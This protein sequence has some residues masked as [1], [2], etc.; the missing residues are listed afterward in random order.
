MDENLIR[1]T[2]GGEAGFWA[3]YSTLQANGVTLAQVRA[4]VAERIALRLIDR[5]R[6]HGSGYI[7]AM[8]QGSA[9]VVS[10]ARNVHDELPEMFTSVTVT[11]VELAIETGARALHDAADADI[12]RAKGE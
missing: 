3:A 10:M 8:A 5:Q 1:Q 6:Q 12:A 4:D 9:A 7:L 2:P 11:A